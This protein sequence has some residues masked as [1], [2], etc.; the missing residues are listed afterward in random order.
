MSTDATSRLISSVR[1]DQRTH[2][3]ADT[4]IAESA[5][6]GAH[7]QSRSVFSPCRAL[8]VLCLCVRLLRPGMRLWQCS[9]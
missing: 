5:Q 3:N 7:M 8:P 1:L 4:D 6:N 9:I 2:R